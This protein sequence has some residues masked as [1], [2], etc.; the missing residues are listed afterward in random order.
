MD[1]PK[2]VESVHSNGSISSNQV[3]RIFAAQVE[4]STSRCHQFFAYALLDSGANSCF[5]DRNFALTHNILLK[6]LHCPVSVTVIDGRPIASGDITEES[7]SVRVVLGDLACVISFNIIHSPE[8]PIVLGLPWFELHNPQIDWRKRVILESKK[9]HISNFPIAYNP[10]LECHQISTISLENL[11]KEGQKEEM[12]IFAIITMPTPTQQ[13][14]TTLLPTKYQEFQDVF[15]KDKASRLPEHRPYDCPIDLQPGKDPPWGPIYSLS[16][17]ELKVL[18]DYIDENLATG[19]IRHSKSPAGAPIFFVKKKDG[20][21]RLVV[22]YRGLN[23]ITIRNRYALPLIPTLLERLSGAKYFTKLDLRGAYN[24]VRIRPGDE[25][26]TAFRTRYGHFEYTV[27][28]FGLTNAPAVFQHMANDIFRDFL[29]IF[30]IIYLDDILIFS[31]TQEEHDEHVR[32]VLRRLQEYGL[33]AK[34]EK[35]SFDLNQVEFLGYIVSSEGISMDPAKVQTIL[36]WR[37]PQSVRDVQCFLGFANFYRKFIRNYSKKVLPL[38]QLTHKNQP[39]IWN[40]SAAEAFESLKHAF[41]SAPILI[42]ANQ[43]KP[44]ILEADASDFAL[45][46]VLS[47]P[48]ENGLLYP[49]AFHS[50]KFEAAEINYEIHDK[51]L[52]AI[53]DS[54]EHWRHFLEGSPHQIIV[55]NDHKNLT[56]FQNAR[57]LNRRQARWAQFL[58]R[59]D[60]LIVY[61]PAIHQG[62]ADALSRRSY[63]APCL[64]EP[65]FDHQK[66]IL[67]GPDRLQVMVVNAFKMPTDSMLISTIRTDL[68]ADEFAQDVLNHIIPD[69]ASC[70]RSVNSR[71]DYNQFSWHDNLLFRNNLLYVP[72]GRSRLLILQHCHDMPMAGHFGVHKTLE[73]VSRNYWWPH[74]RNYV[75]DYIRSC[76]ACCRSKYPRHRPYGLLQPLQVPDGPWKSIS[77]D[78][79]T[80]LPSSKGFDSILTVVDRF[81]K[82]AHFLPC[83]KTIN[84]QETTDLVMRE[85]FRHHGLPDDIISDR[86]PQFIST[87]WKHLFG[88]LQIDCKLSSSYHPETDG[89][90][91][92]TNQTLEQYLR[93]F[94]NYQQDD[95]VDYLH[96]A[97]FSYNN[98]V[99]SSTKLTPFFA[100]TGVHPRWTMLDH[101]KI[102]KNPAA[103]DR[104]CHIRE[105]HIALSHHLQHAQATHKKFADRHRLNSSSEK[106]KFQVGD[107]VWL[108]RHNV[109]TTRPCNKLDYQRLGPYLITKQINE[110]AFQLDL[111]PHMRLHPVFHV[112]LL[113]PYASNSIP[114][115][116]VPP[117]PP[118]EFDEGPE[119]EVKAILDS[120]VVK[121]K[122]Y[123]LV[124]WLGYTPADRT[125]EPAE[126]LNNTKELVAE[127]HQQY[128]N[129]PTPSSCI[130]TRGTRR[131]RKG[132]MS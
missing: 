8:H 10:N 129:K 112:S 17:V 124:D 12:F 32:Q 100:N 47:Q 64:G 68:E 39:F 97:E 35:C 71:N 131:Q 3:N 77:M 88:L 72:D 27:M 73:L 128:P 18:R 102:S 91:E 121:N 34:L 58:T 11:R 105:I 51:E 28:P 37:T 115:R 6:P 14:S 43:D 36:E 122:L 31:K 127:F 89:Q 109:K 93:C 95:W 119:Y 67:L 126:N 23:K 113:E 33:Y 110:V 90:T 48:N 21:L 120:K 25:W 7:E 60:F 99:H 125:W 80:D 15:N 13:K 123:Y 22:D 55:Y 52:L 19:F 75:E 40:S 86:G 85:V 76:D 29:D 54:F 4:L 132:I 53:V 61:R 74:L 24:L 1:N 117:P 45:G 98:S 101:P 49:V 83:T 103:E 26:K 69:R 41:T 108:L 9:T 16:P 84:S 107:R 42:H 78:F 106:P 62:K 130:A 87:F 81:T 5:M 104:L 92:R 57:V 96:F 30:T 63:M 70:S 82:M 50:R 94:I 20:S 116:V 59:F 56:Y 2:F 114:G 38:T 79:I 66:Q 118:I 65:T 111:P 46:S 44:F